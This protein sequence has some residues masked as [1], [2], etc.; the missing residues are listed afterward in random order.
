MTDPGSVV[1]SSRSFGSGEDDPTPRLEAAGHRVVRIAPDHDLARIA[2]PLRDAVAWIAGTGPVTADHLDAAPALRVVARYG[3]GVDAVD[4][5]A[6]VDRGVVV[7]NTPAANADAVADHTIGLTLAALRD[8]VAGDAAVRAG[9]WS[10]RR[11]RELGACTVGLVGFGA[12]G[13]AVARRLRGFGSRVVIH[14]PY[15]SDP[16]EAVTALDLTTLLTG[17]DVVSLHAPGGD[18]P[19]IDAAALAT[20]RP[21]AVLVNL[22]RA[23]LVD[24]AAVAEALVAGRLGAHASD[25][26]AGEHGGASPLLTAPRTILTPHVAGQTVEA[27]DRMGRTAADDVL[28]ILAGDA[29]LHPV[30]APDAP[31]PHRRTP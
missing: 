16:G 29:A 14:D 23:S 31:A 18:R 12:V 6:A 27:I 4:V 24:E 26:V 15:V 8:V 1:V 10:R 7:T 20:M 21:D 9:D 5:A 2:D 3:V 11:G 17:S 19:I 25:V 22:A 28:R 13:R 30:D